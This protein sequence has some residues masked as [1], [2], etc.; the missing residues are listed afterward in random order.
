M[1]NFKL[2]MSL[3]RIW[4]V[5]NIVVFLEIIAL[6]LFILT[7][8]GVL[9][10][11]FPIFGKLSGEIKEALAD[12]DN[13]WIKVI[14]VLSS[15]FMSVS[16]FLTK[17]KSIALADIKNDNV[18]VALIRAGFYF[19]EKGQLVKK[20]EKVTNKDLDGDGKIGDEDA[21]EGKV[22]LGLFSGAINAVQEFFAIAS[23]KI[24]DTKSEKEAYSDALEQTNMTEA[25]A[26]VDDMNQYIA[27]KVVEN[28][29][30]ISADIED[31]IKEKK[32]S[33]A[34]VGFFGNIFLWV[35]SFFER[36]KAKR[37]ARKLSKQS[38]VF[39][40]MTPDSLNEL[41][42]AVFD[43]SEMKRGAL[44]VIMGKENIF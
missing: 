36:A 7:F 12:S 34:T 38:R 3:L 25:A 17:A 35:K 9:P 20:Y 33:G 4:F 14:S 21:G 18:K 28:A 27:D 23:L 19:N 42:E 40:K 10:A 29:P 24:D 31:A 16:V 22:S 41:Q 43:M 13:G 11:G 15:S 6:I 39:Q 44:F 37:L 30:E 8:T 26:A 32:E 5:K 1:K 2:K